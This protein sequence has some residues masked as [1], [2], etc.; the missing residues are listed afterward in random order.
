MLTSSEGNFPSYRAI[1]LAITAPIMC[2]VQLHLPSTAS[3]L[4]FF[5]ELLEPFQSSPDSKNANR[6][7]GRYMDLGGRKKNLG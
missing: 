2:I 5:V 3:A 7:I 6:K 1:L 4:N